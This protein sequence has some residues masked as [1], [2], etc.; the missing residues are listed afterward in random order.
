MNEAD[1][2][3]WTTLYKAPTSAS[4]SQETR[5]TLEVGIDDLKA[6][7]SADEEPVG[8]DGLDAAALEA[9]ITRLVNERLAALGPQLA[10]AAA[11]A[12][13]R[14]AT[15]T[16]A[17]AVPAAPAAP[18][19]K[20]AASRPGDAAP[21]FV[22]RPPEPSA[23]DR[24]SAMEPIDDELG[25]AES[26]SGVYELSV[27]VPEFEPSPTPAEPSMS[28]LSD[29]EFVFELGSA[30]ESYEEDGQEAKVRKMYESG[31]TYSFDLGRED[32]SPSS[33]ELTHNSSDDIDVS[34]MMESVPSLPRGQG[35]LLNVQDL[36]TESMQVLVMVDGNT[37]LRGLRT[38]VAHIPEDRFLE[39]MGEA[40]KRGLVA[41]E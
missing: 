21:V 40:L 37:N 17:A 36:S 41:F 38:L 13:P 20:A 16:P 27:D 28:D 6:E 19:A 8:L 26:D 23:A 31:E 9:L 3:F 29:D 4:S 25:E 2:R 5:A 15:S 1:P 34:S 11:A 12:P 33:I 22:P 24:S 35:G 30:D 32:D 39:I 10:A 18:A 14:A 7:I